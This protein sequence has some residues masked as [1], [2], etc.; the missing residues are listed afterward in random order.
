M[1]PWMLKVLQR[2]IDANK[3]PWFLS[4]AVRS[5]LQVTISVLVKVC[6]RKRMDCVFSTEHIFFLWSFFRNDW[7]HSFPLCCRNC[8]QWLLWTSRCPETGRATCHCRDADTTS[9]PS[10]TVRTSNATKSE[11]HKLFNTK[12]QKSNPT[13]DCRP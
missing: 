13:E 12:G 10:A 1:V 9:T 2:A 5:L 7:H 3:E 8:P 4:V 6:E 11:V